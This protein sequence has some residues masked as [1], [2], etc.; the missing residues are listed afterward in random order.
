MDIRSRPTPRPH[1]QDPCSVQGVSDYLHERAE[2]PRA[3]PPELR[4]AV[5]LQHKTGSSEIVRYSGQTTADGQDIPAEAVV[6]DEVVIYVDGIGQ[7]I[8]EQQRQ[9]AALLHGGSEA[10]ADLDRPIIGVHEGQGKSGTSDVLRI[11]KNTLF[12]KALQTGLAPNSLIEKAAYK[13]DPSIKSIKDLLH[14]SLDAGLKVTLMAHSGG[15]SQ[16]ALALNL[17]SREQGGRFQKALADDV[18]LLSIAGA[19]SAEDYQKGGL[20][21]ENLLYTGSQQDEVYRLFHNHIEP[22]AWHKNLPFIGDGI[23]VLRG[24]NI[25][26]STHA[27]DYLFAEHKTGEANRLEDFLEGGRGGYYELE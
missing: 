17:L 10:G 23:S 13:N 26:K 24:K 9:I 7:R 25:D 1:R 11:A 12:T 5:L 16:V 3:E 21:P 14:Q 15:G 22:V 20:N 27:P 2:S 4:G 18:R 6:N 8:K 19:A